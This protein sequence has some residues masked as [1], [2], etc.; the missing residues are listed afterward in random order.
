MTAEAQPVQVREP[1]RRR[2]YVHP[3]HSFAADAPTVITTILGSCVSVCLFDERIRIGGITHYVLPRP[4]GG[5]TRLET[6]KIGTL[7]VHALVNELMSLGARRERMTAKVFGGASMLAQVT[8]TAR[9]LGAQNAAIGLEIL[10]ELRIRVVAQDVGGTRGR[11]LVFQT[12]DG[13]AWIK[14]LESRP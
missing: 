5:T 9:D 8:N 10:S 1:E 4:L 6:G 2:A 12:D 3:G 13:A 11:K 7:A 14:Y